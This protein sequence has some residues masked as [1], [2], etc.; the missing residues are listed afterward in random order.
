MMMGYRCLDT[1]LIVAFLTLGML[2]G[3]GKAMAESE[4]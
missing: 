4:V 2:L 3:V 1:G